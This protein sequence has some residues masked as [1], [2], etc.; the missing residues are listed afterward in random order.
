M[1]L[2]DG[3]SSKNENRQGGPKGEIQSYYHSGAP[4]PEDSK[5]LVCMLACDLHSNNSS[6]A[7]DM[8]SV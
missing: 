4:L 6:G 7:P 3:N 1:W 2:T 5:I 8:G